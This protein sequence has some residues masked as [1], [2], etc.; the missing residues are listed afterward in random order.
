MYFNDST[1]IEG[2]GYIKNNKIFFKLE[3]KEA[4]SEWSFESV[5]RIDFYGFENSVDGEFES[6]PGALKKAEN[7]L[8]QKNAL[9]RFFP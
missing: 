7:L 4:F 3:E 2:L 5:Y 8:D 1:S 6:W 9:S